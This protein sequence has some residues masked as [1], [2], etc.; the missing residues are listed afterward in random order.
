[1]IVAFINNS[2]EI[3]SGLILENDD[4]FS[5]DKYH[6]EPIRSDFMYKPYTF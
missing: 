5:S 2:L 3:L 4:S 6:Y 1:M